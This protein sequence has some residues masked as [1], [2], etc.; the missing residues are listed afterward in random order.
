M[1]AI[2]LR[3]TPSDV[4]YP[5]NASYIDIPINQF[6]SRQLSFSPS[7]SL[8]WLNDIALGLDPWDRLIPSVPLLSLTLRFQIDWTPAVFTTTQPYLARVLVVYDWNPPVIQPPTV[9]VVL[10]S[11]TNTGTTFTDV[12]SS[13]ANRSRFSILYDEF[14]PLPGVT[15]SPSSAYLAPSI[16]CPSRDLTLNLNS[17]VT[18]Y[19]DL[20]P[21]FKI[22]TGALYLI[23]IAD[24]FPASL[25][26]SLKGTARLYFSRNL[27]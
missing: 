8:L 4:V 17:V 19:N 10:K 24:D 20:A 9:D 3:A 2:S 16:A 27:P 18:L 26:W 21:T 22:T 7:G 6:P 11:R 13:N 15:S 12:Y 1:S 5:P 23:A 14:F 25:A